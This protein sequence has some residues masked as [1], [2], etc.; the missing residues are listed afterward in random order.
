VTHAR[1]NSKYFILVVTDTLGDFLGMLEKCMQRMI[2]D[3][4]WLPVECVSSPSK[5]LL[6]F[7]DL[8]LGGALRLIRSHTKYVILCI[9]GDNA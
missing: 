6:P 9:F 5:D 1:K 3:G 4:P 7:T 8:L 2:H